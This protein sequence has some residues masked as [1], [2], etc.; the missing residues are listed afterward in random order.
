MKTNFGLFEWP[1]KT[2]RFYCI[3]FIR[4][5][6][7]VLSLLAMTDL[8]NYMG[9]HTRSSYLLPQQTAEVQASLHKCT[10]LQKPL[11]HIH[12]KYGLVDKDLKQK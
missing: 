3:L 6:M 5:L 11:L 10:D 1:V 12:T 7:H 8:F 9:Q 2:A 4:S